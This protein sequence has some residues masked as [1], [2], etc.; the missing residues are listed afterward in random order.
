MVR[1]KNYFNKPAVIL[2]TQWANQH[3]SWYKSVKNH[4]S[5]LSHTSLLDKDLISILFCFLH[6]SQNKFQS[7][8][9]SIIFMNILCIMYILFSL[10]LNKL[11]DLA[12]SYGLLMVRKD[13]LIQLPELGYGNSKTNCLL[14]SGCL[15]KAEK[16]KLSLQ[17]N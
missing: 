1:K 11:L 4:W 12:T 5:N 3:F 14:Q 15:S 7:P 16:T 2:K 6:L 8:L 10:H 17:Y 13:C 9:L